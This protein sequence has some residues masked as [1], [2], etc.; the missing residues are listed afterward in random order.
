M[1]SLVHVG[2][3]MI[4]AKAITAIPHGIRVSVEL[5][6]A[7]TEESRTAY[8]PVVLVFFC[9]RYTYVMVLNLLGDRPEVADWCS[10]IGDVGDK[11]IKPDPS[12]PAST[13]AFCQT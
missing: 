13:R 12:T 5:A 3:S 10:L 8:A 6:P 7:Y 2:P 11:S 9:F 1:R 4:C